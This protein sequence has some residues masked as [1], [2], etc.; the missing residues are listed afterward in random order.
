MARGNFWFPFYTGDFIAKTYH[1][2]QGQRGAFLSLLLWYYE[3]SRPIPMGFEYGI[4]SASSEEEK[5]NTD[6]VLATYFTKESGLWINRKCDEVIIEINKKREA[7]RVNGSKGGRPKEN[8]TVNP[9]ETHG[10]AKNN[11]TVNPNHNPN[12]THLHLQPNLKI[13][14]QRE[15]IR[16]QGGSFKPS[17]GLK[18]NVLDHLSRI[19]RLEVEEMARK[20]NWDFMALVAKYNAWVGVPPQS[21]DRAFPVWAEN[22]MRSKR[23]G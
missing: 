11:P 9:E 7:Q 22:F 8:P 6:L 4:S 2:S 12:E 23:N 19:V 16:G 10:L 3:N 17:A 5:R 21:A 20:Y 14:D 13:K 18:Y 1:L 15:G